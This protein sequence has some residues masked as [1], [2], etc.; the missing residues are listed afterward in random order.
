MEHD[1]ATVYLVITETNSSVFTFYQMIGF[2][3]EKE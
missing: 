1:V 3:Y 2:M